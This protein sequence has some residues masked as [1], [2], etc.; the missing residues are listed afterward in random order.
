[1]KKLYLILVFICI[2]CLSFAEKT[3]ATDKAEK[4]DI[5][6]N[7]EQMEEIF[8]G[9]KNEKDEFW[10]N[11]SASGDCL[12][13]LGAIESL[14]SEKMSPKE[15]EMLNSLKKRI[16]AFVK[17]RWGKNPPV[18]VKANI[19]FCA[20]GNNKQQVDFKPKPLN[21]NIFHYIPGGPLKWFTLN[22]INRQNINDLIEAINIASKIRE[23]LPLILPNNISQ[24]MFSKLMK[25]INVRYLDF[26]GSESINDISALEYSTNLKELRL[27]INK[28]MK[29]FEALNKL[30]KLE[31][32]EIESNRLFLND[33]T[34]LGKL[35]SLKI[36]KISSSNIK[37]LV[38]LKNFP[39][40]QELTIIGTEIEG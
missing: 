15:K 39:N 23:S 25:N 22:D 30:H 21:A 14:K 34:F 36:L 24:K 12:F 40:L 31:I 37:K 26:I 19:G 20:V 16:T 1:M 28:G 35:P 33:L 7:I 4:I 2:G 18:A 27:F 13:L 10:R 5:A 8:K 29:G 38:G 3:V 9:V 11:S 6:K 32:L 17:Q